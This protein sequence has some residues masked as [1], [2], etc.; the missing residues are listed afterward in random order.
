MSR[1]LEVS[2]VFLH[3]W[4]YLACPVHGMAVKR[5]LFS[6]STCVTEQ[7][8]SCP[9]FLLRICFACVL[10]SFVMNWSTLAHECIA[11]CHGHTEW[12]TYRDVTGQIGLSVLF[13]F[14]F[15][16]TWVLWCLCS[17][18]LKALCRVTEWSPSLEDVYWQNCSYT[19]L[20]MDLKGRNWS[21]RRRAGKGL[22]PLMKT[23]GKSWC[24]A[25]VNNIG[26]CSKRSL[27]YVIYNLVCTSRCVS[28][29]GLWSCWW[30]M[31]RRSHW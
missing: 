16:L 15:Y 26:E 21:R 17:F 24:P 8:H 1:A 6:S 20:M 11:C 29:Q 7:Q 28:P 2:G 14:L 19:L 10:V 27:C 22:D 13:V 9:G 5:L 4:G 23:S 3:V 30:Y 18:T 31:H 25:W 12:W